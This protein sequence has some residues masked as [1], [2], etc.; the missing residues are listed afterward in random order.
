MVAIKHATQVAVPNDP[1]D[2]VS[3]N[4]WN[5]DHVVELTG[6]GLLGR[7][8][9]GL[10]VATEITLGSGLQ[11]TGTVLSAT[12]G[13]GSLAWA[14][15][16][17]KPS[18]FTPSAHTHAIS[19]VTGL[20]TALD[21]KQASG[22]YEPAFSSG[23]TSQFFRGDKTFQDLNKTVVGLGNVD[24]TSDASKP[25]STAQQTALNLKENSITAGTTAQY[26]RGDK[27][28]QTLNAA[29]VGLGN[30]TNTS[31]ANKPVSTAQQTALNLK[32][33]SIT[34]G[35]TAQYW[36]GDK[37]FQTLDKAAVGLA[38]VDNTSDA[39][40]PVSTA[41]QTA[42]NGKAN[43]SHTHVASD[44]TDFNSVARA[45][46]EAEL[47]AGTNVTI[48]PAGTGATRTLTISASGGGGGSGTTTNSITFNVSGGAAAGTTFNG[49]SA[50]TVDYTT[51]GA[52]AA[53]HTHA[54][55]DVTG[56]QTALNGKASLLHAQSFTGSGVRN[57]G[58]GTGP[59]SVTITGDNASD[60]TLSLNRL[61]GTGGSLFW[62]GTAAVLRTTSG[63]TIQLRGDDIIF[64]SQGAV[65]RGN[66]DANGLTL[67]VGKLKL[68]TFT[69]SS[70]ANGDIWFDGTTFKKRQGGTTTDLDTTG[71]GGS[72]PWTYVKLASDFSNN[73][74]TNA[75][76]TGMS[77]TPPDNSTVIVEG[78][79][80]LAAA[81][82]TTGAQFGVAGPTAG[83]TYGALKLAAPSGA[84]AD[85]VT[86]ANFPN[87]ATINSTVV[88]H[89]AT[90]GQMIG[91]IDLFIVTT[92]VTGTVK[93]VLRSE[94][95]TS[96]VTMKAGSY[97]RWRTI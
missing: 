76:V 51:V 11:F 93:L 91:W 85:V 48:T 47:V 20:Q 22:S 89:P 14:D 46:T 61:D 45:Q 19:D 38:N 55:A 27:T 60:P 5:A 72:D 32:E 95:A 73:T 9:N 80:V 29:S 42:L 56:L 52:A 10:G 12:G 82:N 66:I 58:D 74:T 63:G 40:K 87:S 78:L 21:G 53:T 94:I 43:T 15:I 36:R 64:R 62:N 79:V 90:L 35:T 69:N 59:T 2:P 44:V 88:N 84:A 86:H 39:N 13:G 75:D 18:T 3:A 30:V 23:T 24:N 8:A 57:F 96:N 65:T 81:A 41:T 92:T 37:T 28:W 83:I 54:I 6:P 7:V 1:S 34:A 77:F 17:G 31:D 71:G 97:I 4:A 16:T 49:A 67:A 25:V 70:P 26:W 68:P 33:N 50:V